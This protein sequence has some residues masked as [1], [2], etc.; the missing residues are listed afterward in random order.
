VQIVQKTDE[1]LPGDIVMKALAEDTEPHYSTISDFINEKGEEIKT[2]F[3]E[4]LLDWISLGL[5]KKRTAIVVLG[6]RS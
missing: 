6:G 5:M 3:K 1:T 4:V 2:I